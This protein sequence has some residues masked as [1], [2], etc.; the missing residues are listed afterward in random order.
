MN[1]SYHVSFLHVLVAC[2][3]RTATTISRSQ[4]KCCNKK[5]EKNNQTIFAAFSLSL[6]F[7]CLCLQLFDEEVDSDEFYWAPFPS[8]WIWVPDFFEAPRN[9]FHWR[10]VKSS[11]NH[12]LVGPVLGSNILTLCEWFTIDLLIS[13]T[14]Y[15]NYDA[16]LILLFIYLIFLWS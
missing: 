4:T 16:P 10:S 14:L 6:S 15:Q 7:L 13:L 2:L 1:V 5:N 8:V 12:L 9:S 3:V 11:K